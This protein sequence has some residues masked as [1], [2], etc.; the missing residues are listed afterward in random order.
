MQ[1]SLF[2]EMIINQLFQLKTRELKLSQFLL[3]FVND[4]PVLDSGCETFGRL[5]LWN[6]YLLYPLVVG[7]CLHKKCSIVDT[8][9]MCT[10]MDMTY[11]HPF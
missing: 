7:T 6:L 4:L 1:D 9:S 2:D 8:Q 11:P 3:I 5:T 10:K